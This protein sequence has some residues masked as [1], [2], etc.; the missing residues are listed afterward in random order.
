MNIESYL[1]QAWANNAVVPAALT[2][3]AIATILAIN[4][5][6]MRARWQ[7]WHTH[8]G[9]N[10][11]GIKQIKNAICVDGL[12]GEFAIDRLIMLHDVILVTA[13]K[14]YSGNIYCAESIPEWTQ[15]LD[16]KSYKFK[17][18]L[19][20]LGNQVTAIQNYLP[21]VPI[22]GV[23]IFDY[24]ANFPK[25][26]PEHVMRLD[27][28]PNSFLHANCPEPRPEVLK[29]WDALLKL[30]LRREQEPLYQ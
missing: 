2:L 20:E 25:G 17:N 12:D 23:L 30:P 5:R 7:E 9:L 13:F 22:R 28:I 19:F 3:L 4:W 10:K 11:I 6:K 18:P 14:P 24:S 21:G 8:R 29:G 1:S 16:Q 27:N 26:H 15:L